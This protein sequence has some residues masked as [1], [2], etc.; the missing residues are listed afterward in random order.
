MSSL[1]SAF[2]TASL[3]PIL[4]P[5]ELAIARTGIRRRSAAGFTVPAGSGLEN[6]RQAVELYRGVTE[7]PAFLCLG[8]A[9]DS[10]GSC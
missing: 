4:L 1:D 3:S 2:S 7:Q 8:T 5:E 9:L 10:P 6:R